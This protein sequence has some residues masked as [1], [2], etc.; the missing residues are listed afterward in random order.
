V[1]PPTA[2]PILRSLSALAALL[3][4]ATTRGGAR[5]HNPGACPQAVALRLRE[6]RS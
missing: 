5:V 3:L 6:A 2:L 1:G 4:R